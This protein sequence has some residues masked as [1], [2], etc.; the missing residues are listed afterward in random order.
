MIGLDERLKIVVTG[1]GRCGTLFFS[2]LLSGV[3][4]KCGHE[5]VF[6]QNPLTLRDSSKWDADSS[7]FAAPFAGKLESKGIKVVHLVRHPVR[8]IE[9]FLR[10]GYF[11]GENWSSSLIGWWQKH[12]PFPFDQDNEDSMAVAYWIDWNEMIGET[13]FRHRIEDD[14]GS[15]LDKLGIGWGGELFSDKKCNTRAEYEHPDRRLE[16]GKVD[17]GLQEELFRLA[18]SYGYEVEL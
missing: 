3:G 16:L 13:H 15:L 8:C 1:T 12:C 17:E 5:Q 14:S 4:V 6:S 10:M 7:L 9:S 11:D 2:R 18:E